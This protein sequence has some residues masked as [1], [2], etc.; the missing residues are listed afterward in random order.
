MSAPVLH[1]PGR[2]WLHRAPVWAKALALLAAATALVARGGPWQAA[3][4]AVAALA[5]GLSAGIPPRVLARAMVPFA[6][7]AAVM[8]GWQM[9]LG[10]AD[11]AWVS[12]T[13]VVALSLLAVTLTLATRADEVTGAVEAGLRRLGVRHDRVFRFGLAVGVTLRS[14]AHLAVVVADVRDARRARGMTRS[15]RALA[16]PTVV[17]AGRFAHG[18]GEAMECRGLADPDPEEAAAGGGR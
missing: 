9:L 11:A 17:A 7:T 5:A 3:A 18:V 15:V 16:V 12:A 1:W 6:V 13:R 14:V 4:V 2:S 8:W 10:Q